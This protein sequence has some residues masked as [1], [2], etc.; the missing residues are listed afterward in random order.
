MPPTHFAT[1]TGSLSLHKSARQ[2]RDMPS[3]AASDTDR[4][5]DDADAQA[6]M[7]RPEYSLRSVLPLLTLLR[8][9]HGENPH[10]KYVFDYPYCSIGPCC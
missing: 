6:D 9:R 4:N 1:L 5:G 10:C 8:R 3:D 2:R 7:L